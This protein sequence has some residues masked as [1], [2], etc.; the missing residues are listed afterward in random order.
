MKQLPIDVDELIAAMQTHFD[1]ATHYLDTQTGKLELIDETL[2]R[3]LEDEAEDDEDE[4]DVPGWEKELLPIARAIAAGDERY[5]PLPGPD[6]HE[7][8]RLMEQ[9][10]ADVK[11]PHARQRLEDALDGRGAFSR[12]RRVLGDYPELRDQWH[13]AQDAAAREQALEWLAEFGIEAVEKP[14]GGPGSS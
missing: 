9:F 4:L 13:A 2:V 7:D 11:D 14:K 6:P 10:A 8:Y 3:Q 1:E 5:V 12:F